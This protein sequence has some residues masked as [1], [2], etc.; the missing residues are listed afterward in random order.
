[1]AQFLFVRMKYATMA[2]EPGAGPCSHH[3]TCLHYHLDLEIEIYEFQEAEAH[4]TLL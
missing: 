3:S 2:T 1:M 4:E